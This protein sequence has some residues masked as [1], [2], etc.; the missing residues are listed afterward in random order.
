VHLDDL[1]LLLCREVPL[2]PLV[3]KCKMADLPVPPVI[4]VAPSLVTSQSFQPSRPGPP[5][6]LE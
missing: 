4:A 2:L 5:W 6:R 3:A 1:L